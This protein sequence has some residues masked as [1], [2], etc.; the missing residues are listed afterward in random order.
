MPDQG[1]N[2]CRRMLA[3]AVHEQ[4]STE[5]RM[6]EAGHQRRFL[7]EVAR[8]RNDLNVEGLGWQRLRHSQA[9]V[10]AAVIDIDHFGREAALLPE[11]A[12]N[13]GEPGVKPGKAG[14]LVEQ[15]NHDRQ[16][17]LGGWPGGVSG[18][19]GCCHSHVTPLSMLDNL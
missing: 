11:P 17:G 12:G 6:I 4:H 3:V 5:P 7:A 18:K 19:W 2:Q 14:A 1:R 10:A 8:Q 16:T 15:G 13:L 9:V